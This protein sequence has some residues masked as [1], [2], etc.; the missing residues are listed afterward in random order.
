MNKFNCLI[1]IDQENPKIQRCPTNITQETDPGKPTAAVEWEEP[2][3][4]DNSG[5][6]VNVVCNH[7]SGAQFNIGHTEVVCQAVDSSG[8][9]AECQFN[10]TINGMLILKND[11]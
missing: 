2:L 8:N 11:K 10:V 3:A 4:T 1:C 7:V 5:D 9:K 6:A